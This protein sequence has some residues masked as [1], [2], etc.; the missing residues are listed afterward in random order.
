MA[1]GYHGRILHVDLSEGRSWAEEP[2]TNWYRRYG[3]GGALG[4]FFLLRDMDPTVDAFDPGNVMV[5]AS[6]VVAGTPVPGVSKHSVIAKS[7]L[8]GGIGESQSSGPFGAAFK[9]S[10]ADALVVHGAARRPVYPVVAD[11]E[12]EIRDGSGLWGLETG[13]ASDRIES[14]AGRPIHVAAIGPAGERRVRFASI[15]NDSRFVNQRCGLGAV[16][17]SK[18]LKAVAVAGDVPATVAD[19]TGLG[20][21]AADYEANQLDIPIMELQNRLGLGVWQDPDF[22]IPFSSRNFQQGVFDGLADIAIQDI[23]DQYLVDAGGCHACPTDCMRRFAVPDGVN[24]TAIRYGNLDHNSGSSFGQ[25]VGCNDPEALLKANELGNRYGLDPESCGHTIAWAMEC[26]ERGLIDQEVTGGL[27]LRFGNAAAMVRLVEQ[28]GLRE[29]F[30]DV[31][32]EG[33][34]RAATRIGRGTDEFVMCVKGKE[35]PA[36]EPRNKPGLALIYAVGP[37]GPD[38]CGVEHDPD[39]DP[40][41]G[42]PYAL[43]KGRAFGLLEWLPEQ[44]MSP[45][46]IRQTVVLERWWSG[47]LESLLFCL[48]ATAPVRYMPPAMMTKAVGSATGWDF[49]L[50][51]LMQI[52]ER[53]LNMFRVFNQRAGLS[54]A[55]DVLPDRFFDETIAGGPY[56]GV[57]LDPQEFADGRRLYYDMVGWDA[58]GRPNAAKL[59]EL[60]LGWLAEE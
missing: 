27:D 41:V 17:G 36:H 53:R 21:V 5:F 52:G 57:K 31:L 19:P 34:Q 58:E 50:W 20:E 40:E 47:A 54:S 28:I 33:S 11:A 6:S 8:T 46:K 10:G 29:G 4:A 30:G 49:S 37:I 48:Y 60:E 55:D 39:F 14:E 15:V 26:F 38:F 42:V 35:I 23:S 16:M 12:V 13:P 3:G 43:D 1:D 24:A 51:E 7:P 22:P 25:I 56:D 32:A 18:N 9:R 44:E 45:R 2:D 59:H